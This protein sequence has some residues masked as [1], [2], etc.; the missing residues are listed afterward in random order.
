M[1]DNK[2]QNKQHSGPKLNDQMLIRR[3]RDTLKKGLQAMSTFFRS[4]ETK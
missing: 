3:D 1:T 4:L 2:N